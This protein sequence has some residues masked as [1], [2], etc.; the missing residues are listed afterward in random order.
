MA[1]ASAPPAHELQG[2]GENIL[3]SPSKHALMPVRQSGTDRNP[4]KHMKY[5]ALFALAAIALSLGAC[6]KH[7]Q[8]STTTTHAASTGYSK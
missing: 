3:V 1:T 2:E 6:A 5:F 4:T 8:A 7:E